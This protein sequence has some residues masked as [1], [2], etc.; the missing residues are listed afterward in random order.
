MLTGIIF[1]VYGQVATHEFILYDDPVYVNENPTVLA[2]LTADNIRWAFTTLSMANWHPLTWLSYLLDIQLFGPNP[3]AMLLENV[4]IH[5]I[6]TIL[7]FILLKRLTGFFWRSAI[8]AALFALHPLHVESVAWISERKDVLSTLFWLLTLYFHARYA[9]RRA[10]HFYLLALGA[11][12]LGLLAKPMLVSLPLIMLLMDYWPLG[13]TV[14]AEKNSRKCMSFSRLVVEKLPFI[15]LA[16]ASCWITVIAQSG[17]MT[18]LVVSSL[19]NRISNSLVSYAAYLGK[20][21]WPTALSPFYPFPD[22]IPV[23]QPVAAALLLAA[24]SLLAFRERTRRPYLI[25][26]WLWYLITLVPVIGIVRVGMHAIAD[27]YTYVPLIGIFIMLVWG[28]TDLWEARYSNRKPFAIATFLILVVCSFLTWRQTSYWKNSATLFRHAH[29]VTYNNHVA[30]NIL[31]IDQMK[32][33]NHEEALKLFDQSVREAPWFIE[34]YIHKGNL[35]KK[36]ER[37][38][39]AIEV[40]NRAMVLNPYNATVYIDLGNLHATQGRL[41]EAIDYLLLGLKVDPRSGSAHYNLAMVLHQ[42]GRLDEAIQ[43]YNQSLEFSPGFPDTHNNLGIALAESGKI[44]EAIEQFREALRLKPD[45][46][47]AQKN[48]ERALEIKR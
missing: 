10:I 46:I 28:T 45:Y 11:F 26:G 14:P 38:E 27:R 24:I 9:E 47:E 31:G 19:A 22:S 16:A 12:A 34:P 5:A 37:N 20:L 25:V 32:K 15:A 29:A 41:D 30:S 4:A 43:H 6:N 13:R 7:L 35:L 44:E 2:G 1:A 33:G 40:F 39:E 48:L 18:S 21:F 3:G 17:A 42:Q 36:L 23:W 8:V